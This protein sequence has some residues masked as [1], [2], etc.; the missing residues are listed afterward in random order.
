MSPVSRR[1]ARDAVRRRLH[2][3]AVAGA[4]ATSLCRRVPVDI[5]DLHARRRA[6]ADHH[7]QKPLHHLVAEMMVGL[8]FVA[9][10]SAHRCRSRGSVLAARASNPQRYGGTSQEAPTISP[11]PSV[12]NTIGGLARGVQISSATLPCAD[13][14]ELVGGFALAEQDTARAR[15]AGCARSRPAIGRTRDRCRR[16]TDAPGRCVQAPP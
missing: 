13:Q 3:S 16:R 2:G 7:R 8:A 6:A 15:S 11:S 1:T 10:A 12:A 9:Q 5:E 4:R 14:E